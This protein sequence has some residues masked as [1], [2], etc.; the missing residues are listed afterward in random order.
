MEEVKQKVVSGITGALTDQIVAPKG[1]VQ[2]A[3]QVMGAP[4]V[5]SYGVMGEG[6][7]ELF[8]KVLQACYQSFENTSGL[9]TREGLLGWFNEKFRI[10][11]LVYKKSAFWRDTFSFDPKFSKEYLSHSSDNLD[12]KTPIEIQG[13][14]RDYQNR[15]DVLGRSP[16]VLK[17]AVLALVAL[18]VDRI[19]SAPGSVNLEKRSLD[20]EK[21]I[22][23]F[24]KI[25][26]DTVFQVL[27]EGEFFESSLQLCI[28]TIEKGIN[29]IK[30]NLEKPLQIKRWLDDYSQFSSE[31][32]DGL[33]KYL[34]HLIFNKIVPEKLSAVFSEIRSQYFKIFSSHFFVKIN[35]SKIKKI[36]KIIEN[37]DSDLKK[38]K[39]KTIDELLNEKKINQSDFGYYKDYKNSPILR[40]SKPEEC[41]LSADQFLRELIYEY[42]SVGFSEKNKHLEEIISFYSSKNKEY[43]LYL[44]RSFVLNPGMVMSSSFGKNSKEFEFFLNIAVN[45]MNSILFDSEKTADHFFSVWKPGIFS[46]LYSSVDQEKNIKEFFN[47]FLQLAKCSSWM[48]VYAWFARQFSV[49]SEYMGSVFVA[50]EHGKFF[51]SMRDQTNI[52]LLDVS[53]SILKLEGQG[54]IKELIIR[55]QKKNEKI[56]TWV[57]Q[58]SKI[59]DFEFFTELKKNFCRMNQVCNNLERYTSEESVLK[60][61][62]FSDAIF[63][64]I[65]KSHDQFFPDKKQQNQTL[66]DSKKFAEE[67]MKA[68]LQ[69]FVIT[70]NPKEEIKDKKI[71]ENKKIKSAFEKIKDTENIFSISHENFCEIEKEISFLKNSKEIFSI[72]NLIFDHFEVYID[73]LEKSQIDFEDFKKNASFERL[74]IFI[75]VI[76]KENVFFLGFDS[77]SIIKKLNFFQHKDYFFEEEHVKFDEIRKNFLELKSFFKY[78][79]KYFLEKNLFIKHND[80]HLK[81]Y[82]S[83]IPETESVNLEFLMQFKIKSCATPT[84]K[85]QKLP[86][87]KF[88]AIESL[89]SDKDNAHAIQYCLCKLNLVDFP[90]P[91]QVERERLLT[92]ALDRI[93]DQLAEATPDDQKLS[94]RVWRRLYEIFHFYIPD[95]LMQHKENQNRIHKAVIALVQHHFGFELVFDQGKYRLFHD[96]DRKPLP[97]EALSIRILLPD[98]AR[99]TLITLLNFMLDIDACTIH[100]FL[101]V[102]QK[103]AKFNSLMSS[104]LKAI[105]SAPDLQ[106]A[107]VIAVKL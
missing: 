43:D 76:K 95:Q 46:D 7:A 90:N 29:F 16:G 49:Y 100:P 51:K 82:I 59:S 48:S 58:Q 45:S 71:S 5:L 39:Q 80:K 75:D 24:K 38:N 22:V 15:K 69:R 83:R 62:Q 36:K 99:M 54:S 4:F 21:L 10:S 81:Q 17:Q 44:F 20:L 93:C 92:Y 94:G 31:I 26:R 73:D 28:S 25:E 107:T 13:I 103:Y 91:F 56:K 102:E 27:R 61:I 63:D 19:Y 77:E 85:L 3:S 1:E 2:S 55:D 84:K 89:V 33:T 41:Y 50:S 106:P 52:L 32:S 64:E 12:Y 79:E 78:N 97:K 14:F 9:L 18:A 70:E 104:L 96:P 37:I 60:S 88:Q 40:Q 35:Q 47:I 98:F 74:L 66:R 86:F 87:E 30:Q 8:I 68:Y 11:Q 53:A 105:E 57:S 101:S 34:H 6:D 23:F 67:N 42:S 72:F 65:I